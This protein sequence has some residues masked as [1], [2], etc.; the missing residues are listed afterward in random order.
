MFDSVRERFGRHFKQTIKNKINVK[1][2]IRSNK[3]ELHCI[4]KKKS[5][6]RIAII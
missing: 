4:L 2:K 3:D 6:F 5:T 1:H